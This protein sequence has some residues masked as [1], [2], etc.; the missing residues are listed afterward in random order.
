MSE[1]VSDE[2]YPFTSIEQMSGYGVPERMDGVFRIDPRFL[3]I[4]LEKL[5]H[6]LPAEIALSACE[7]GV[8]GIES[9]FEVFPD[10]LL[11][12]LE[13]RSFSA[14]PAFHSIDEYL[15]VFKVDVGGF[16]RKSF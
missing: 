3:C 1:V 2:L 11:G 7:Q 13:E 9:D 5:M 8:A 10:K 6:S 15:F 4:S 14:D 16:E 12:S